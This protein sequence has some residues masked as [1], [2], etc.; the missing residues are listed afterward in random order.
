[1]LVQMVIGRERKELRYYKLGLLLSP[2]LAMRLVIFYFLLKTSKTSP[3]TGG[4]LPFQIW[5]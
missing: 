4:T 2:D 5:L 3:N 1:M